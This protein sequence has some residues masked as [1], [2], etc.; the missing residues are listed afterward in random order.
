M[1]TSQWSKFAQYGSRFSDL[2]SATL[3]DAGMLCLA[4]YRRADMEEDEGEEGEQEEGDGEGNSE[5]VSPIIGSQI[6]S[7]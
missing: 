6:L 5:K 3:R 1:K 4:I 7:C 2:Y